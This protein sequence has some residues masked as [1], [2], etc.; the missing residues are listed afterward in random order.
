MVQAHTHVYVYIRIKGKYVIIQVS[1]IHPVFWNRLMR[2]DYHETSYLIQVMSKLITSFICN[3]SLYLRRYRFIR[4]V[5]QLS[6]KRVS[7]DLFQ[8][9]FYLKYHFFY[10]NCVIGPQLDVKI[11]ALGTVINRVAYPAD[12]CH[13][14]GAGRQSQPMPIRWMA[15]ES[16][17]KVNYFFLTQ[18]FIIFI[19]KLLF[20]GKIHIKIWCM[21]IRCDTLGNIDICERTT[22]RT[23]DWWKGDR[24]Y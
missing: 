10:R 15:W 16:V 3:P 2:K 12:Y 19:K 22:I 24:E 8:S 14:E 1:C 6:F 9:V 7:F 23:L 21:V 13:L 5:K 20:I 4:H 11:L 17:L 18:F